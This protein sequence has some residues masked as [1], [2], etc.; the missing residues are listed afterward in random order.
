[1]PAF[2]RNKWLSPLSLLVT[3]GVIHLVDE[4]IL[5][6]IILV[7]LWF[8]L[9]RP[10]NRS[11]LL[12][13]LIAAV[14]IVGQNYSVLERG[15]FAFEEKDFLLMPFYEP[16]LW[17]F[18]YLNVKRFFSEDRERPRLEPRAFAGVGI[19]AVC[20]SAFGGND[21][22][23][24]LA[25]LVSTGILLWMFHR[26][27]DLYYAAYALALGF[28]VEIF[29]VSTGLWS[30]P[31]PDFLGMPYWSATMWISVG[32]LGRRFLIPFSE[33]LSGKPARRGRGR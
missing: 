33:W 6:P 26:P 23:L 19:T 11:D 14:F 5:V 20:F 18:Y 2:D 15:G 24:L 29:G 22:R 9:F 7:P 13:F 25:T 21:F 16:F 32:I 12:M 30:Y 1:M 17:G 27:Y 3:L 8:V 10:F 4:S 28:V 31:N